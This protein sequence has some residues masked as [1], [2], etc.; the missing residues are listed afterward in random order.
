MKAQNILDTIGELIAQGQL[1]TALNKLRAMLQQSKRLD[2]IIVQSARYNEVMRDIREGTIT[3]EEG[4]VSKNQIRFAL[5]DMARTLEEELSQDA[6]LG[7]EI[8]QA[9]TEADKTLSIQHSKNVN[10]GNIQSG[11][12]VIIGDNNTSK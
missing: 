1:E 6:S 5:M 11:G 10:T 7:T 9:A 12:N 4:Q 2:A 8:E 3:R